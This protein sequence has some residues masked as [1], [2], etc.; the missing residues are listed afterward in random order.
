MPQRG[1]LQI[2]IHSSGNGMHMSVS[3]YVHGLKFAILELFRSERE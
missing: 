3:D 1:K 2:K